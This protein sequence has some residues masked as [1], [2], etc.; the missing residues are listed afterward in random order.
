MRL[1]TLKKFCE[2]LRLC[3]RFREQKLKHPQA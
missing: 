3:Y 1:Y 2:H